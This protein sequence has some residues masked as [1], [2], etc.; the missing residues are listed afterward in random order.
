MKREV[1]FSPEELAGRRLTRRRRITLPATII[2]DGK[3]R[4]GELVDLSESGARIDRASPDRCDNRVI[5]VVGDQRFDAEV[6]W[7]HKGSL[8]LR[9]DDRACSE[10]VNGLAA[11]AGRK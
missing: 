5:L 6:K 9:F 2:S 8:G 3:E 7:Q 4:R 1:E 10:L 11:L